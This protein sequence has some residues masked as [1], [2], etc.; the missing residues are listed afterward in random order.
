MTK[1]E[2]QKQFEKCTHPTKSLLL[3]FGVVFGL[4]LV[5]LIYLFSPDSL[6]K[7]LLVILG[8]LF[9]SMIFCSEQLRCLYSDL[10]WML[11]QFYV[12]QSN[13][14]EKHA[15]TTTETIHNLTMF[16]EDYFVKVS[17]SYKGQSLKFSVPKSSL[18]QLY[19]NQILVIVVHHQFLPAELVEGYEELFDLRELYQ[20][21]SDF[22]D[23]RGRRGELIGR[24]KE[25][26]NSISERPNVEKIT[27][28]L[29]VINEQCKT[30]K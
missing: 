30:S 15:V 8:T 2:L 7:V 24:H 23:R 6:N 1:E 22:I 19:A 26:Y 14:L 27:F 5:I 16:Y 13:Y 17:F 12:E 18:P 28:Q 4:T 21:Y 9:I 29:A 11:D 20:T 3:P 25:N 10:D